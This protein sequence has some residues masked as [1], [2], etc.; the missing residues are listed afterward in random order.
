MA[1]RSVYLE[2]LDKL[3]R[4]VIKMGSI[5]ETSISMTLKNLVELR[6]D[7]AHNIIERDDQIDELELLVE[8][9]CIEIIAKQQPVASDLRRI[10]SIIKLVTDIERI[11]DHCSDISEY[12]LRLHVQERIEPPKNLFLMG[13]AMKGMANGVIMSYINYD[14]AAAK[15]VV[16]QDDIVD[17]FFHQ[18]MNELSAMMQDN[19]AIV[20]QCMEYLMITKYLERMADHSA[21]IAKWVGFLVTGE[22]EG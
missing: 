18:L 4:H 9:E 1:T 7:V 11:A 13:E 21:N 8:R 2:E 10:T 22:L 17:G 15:A 14:A 6:E 12:V 3:N 19:P 5:L 20:P 16:H